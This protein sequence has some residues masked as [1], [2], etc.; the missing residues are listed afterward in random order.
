VPQG[1]E[2]DAGQAGPGRGRLQRPQ[3]VPGVA[4]LSD[5]GDEHE[6]GVPPEL[7][8]QRPSRSVRSRT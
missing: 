8:G 4:G 2:A 1:V 3:R 5:V 7:P 6:A